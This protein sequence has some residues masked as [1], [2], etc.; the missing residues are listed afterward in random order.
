[1]AKYVNASENAGFKKNRRVQKKEYVNASERDEKNRGGLLE[2]AGYLAGN[3]GLG[4]AGVGEGIG[5]IVSAGA[6]LLRGDTEMAKYRFLDNRTA[7]AQQRLQE[8]YNPNWAMEIAGEVASGIGNSLVFMIPYAGRW[9]AGAG[10]WGQGI[11]KAADKTGDVGLKEVAF[12]L[13][14]AT[15]EFLLEKATGGM[16]FAAK[17]IGAS[18]IR[19][20]GKEAVEATGKA[21]G[22]KAVSTMGGSIGKEIA[23][24][25][26]GEAIEEMASEALDPVLQKAFKVDENAET[27]LENVLYAGLIGGLSGGLMTTGPA[28]MNYASAKKTG[29]TIREKGEAQEL[30]DYAKLLVNGA[31]RFASKSAPKAEAPEGAGKLQR[32]TTGVRNAATGINRWW[33][34]NGAKRLANTLQ[35]NISAYES[36]LKDPKV[37]ADKIKLYDAV[38]GE[39]RGN[40]FLLEADYLLDTYEDMILKESEENQQ[41]VVN[42]INERMAR[43]GA[44]KRDYTLE[45]LK[46]NEDGILTSYATAIMSEEISDVMKKRTGKRSPAK[47]PE[48]AK[49]ATKAAETVPVVQTPTQTQKPT[50][51]EYEPVERSLR[52]SAEG[53]GLSNVETDMM[54]S[55]FKR[56]TYMDADTFSKAFAEGVYYGRQNRRAEDVSK[57]TLFGTMSEAERSAAIEAGRIGAIAEEDKRAAAAA[58]MVKPARQPEQQ[59]KKTYVTLKLADGKRMRDMS[60]RD[61]ATYKAANVIGEALQTDIVLESSLGATESGKHING[62]F[63]RGDNTIHIALG[64]EQTTGKA[65]IFTLAH[66]TTHYIREWAPREYQKLADFVGERLSPAGQT[67]DDMIAT[68]KN[69]LK[70]L[71]DF[72]DLSESDLTDAA[73]EEVIADS[74]ETILT[75]GNVLED[76]ATYDKSLWE[77]VKEWITDAL[78]KIRTAFEGLKPNS[79]AAKVLTETMDS[80]TEL[81]RLFTEGVTAAGERT[82]GAVMVKDSKDNS[83][84]VYHLRDALRTLGEYDATRKR[85]IESSGK[86]RIVRNYDEI[87]AFIQSS[88]SQKEFERIHIGIINPKTANLVMQKTKQN[89]DGYDVVL[90]NEFIAHIFHDHGDQRKETPR[91]QIAV[92]T[93]NVEDLVEAMIDPDDVKAVEADTGPALRFEKSVGNKNVALTITSKKKGTLTLKSA[94]IVENSGGRTPSSNADALEETSE[95]NGRSSAESSIPQPDNSVNSKFSISEEN[96]SEQDENQDVSESAAD[97]NVGDTEEVELSDRDL[98]LAMAEQMVGTEEEYKIVADY[99]A[100][101]DGILAKQE[102]ADELSDR[103]WELQSLMFTGADAEERSNAAKELKVIR[104]ELNNLLDEVAKEDKKLAEIEGMKAIRNLITRE[105]LN[106]RDTFKTKYEGMYKKKVEAK[107]TADKRRQ[108]RRIYNK[109]NRLLFSPTKTRNVPIGLQG[110]VA[111]ALK[112]ANMDVDAMERLAQLEEQLSKLEREAVPDEANI[113]KLEGQIT[114]QEKK[115]GSIKEQTQFLI[116]LLEATNDPNADGETRLVFDA[117]TLQKLKDLQKD[118]GK[119]SVRGMDLKQLTA[120]KDFYD[121]I[122]HRI[123]KANNLLASER[124][125]SVNELGEKASGEVVDAKELKVLSPRGKEWKG[126]PLIRK[127]LW[128]NMKPLTFFEAIGS[129]TLQELFQNVI[130]GEDVWARDLMEAHEFLEKAKKEYGYNKWD[131]DKRSEVKTASGE[132]VSLTLGEKM[133]LYAYMFREQAEQHLSVGGFTFAPDATTIEHFK[134]GVI[135]YEAVLND[136]KQYRMRQEDIAEMAA[137]L[138]AEQKEYARKVQEYLTSLGK[139]GNEVSKKLYGIE[140]FNEQFYFPIRSNRDY[141][142]ESTGKSGDPNIKNQGTFQETVPGAGNPLVLEDFMTV[143]TGHI[144]NMATYHAF[145]LPVEDLTKVWNYTPVNMKRDENG[146]VILDDNGLPVADE[147]A[148][149]SYNSLKAE[150]TKKYGKE[151]NEYI[152]NLIRD[153]NGGARRDA[154]ASILDQG[155]TG[156]KRATTMLSMSTI[157]QQPT[158]I[159]RAMS[160]IDGKYFAGAEL[161]DWEEMKMLAPVAFLKEMGGHDTSTG[162]RTQ[163]YLN[164]KEYD[165]IGDKVK[166][167]L[168][169]K[170]YGGDPKAR[171]EAFGW[172]TSKADE[173]AWR[174]MFGACINE[175]AAKMGKPKDSKEVKEAAAKRF[176]EAVRKT[177]VYDSTLTRSPWMRSKDGLMKIVTSF[178]AEPTTV[179]SMIAE[180]IIKSE[181]GDKK[182]LR[183]IGGVVALSVLAN[184]IASSLIYAMRDDDEDETYAEKYLQSLT[185]EVIEGVN[186][187]EYMPIAREVM[188]LFKGYE[189][190]RTDMTLVSNL[191]EQVE[192]ITSSKRSLPDKLFGVSGAVAAF[193]GVPLTNVYRDAKGLFKTIMGFQTAESQTGA[194]FK[195]AVGDSVR[196]QFN[197]FSKLFGAESGN[198]YEM[199]QAYVRGDTAHYERVKARYES[200]T[201]AEQALRKELRENDKRIGEAAKARIEGEL[202]VYESL[203]EQ[204][205]AEGIFDRNIV[206]R[207]VNNEIILLK[208]DIERGN[209]VPEDPVEEETP[210]SIYTASDLNY[211]LERGEAED[212]TWIYHTLMAYKQEQQGKT[213][214]QARASIKTSVTSYWKKRYTAAW[215]ANNGAEMRRILKILLDTGLYGNH[216][217]TATTLEGWVKAYA[218]AKRK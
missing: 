23:K 1:M 159:F 18:V 121:M 218:K 45:D 107:A 176:T 97:T 46:N 20:T 141:L 195:H 169:P 90:S 77:K 148:A 99:K 204:I 149:R 130:D 24:G 127:F 40:T 88:P 106:V 17:N 80:L 146:E 186:P 172:L 128:G 82:K 157:I 137:S 181:R 191:F 170:T 22:R 142:A 179:M 63:K 74:L 92:T 100:K 76:L 66:E 81:E 33:T 198:A 209:L 94:W 25:F 98:L 134:N 119:A 39:L 182:A 3:L 60:D 47:A 213:E 10:Y 48:A 111:E 193:F 124:K 95:T 215:E 160:L 175:Q 192:M 85:H 55:A 194:G 73:Y 145:V 27:S 69:T 36:M 207:A 65:A 96:V 114:E 9:L 154:A 72:K 14:E 205:E 173:V 185:S 184:A 112:A 79:Q 84:I 168:K 177:Q 4:L 12:G 29:Q 187:L 126:L 35:K 2:G 64:S 150:I 214:A 147:D 135:K 104:D 89:I 113:R 101:Y 34:A 196:S 102:R 197:L 165:S 32:A 44:P 203:V 53:L 87:R 50:E 217:D 67:F 52:Q 38:L 118:I 144:N 183:T 116:E 171:A 188:S 5:D 133:S 162:A 131:M 212:F 152:L 28:V 83:G 16:G 78:A 167:A 61:Y 91:H 26:M 132:T 208:S 13:G 190:E 7:E 103:Q 163:D 211:A 158:S 206:I 19:N 151:A 37:T 6:D 202:E 166:A 51:S 21:I 123:T 42:E 139:K 189:I 110:L 155:I 140:L 86:D 117:E 138:T 210:E 54:V 41:A 156:F 49:E 68:K 56:G 153:L 105:R 174:L 125:I 161:A 122:H 199:Y 8:D 30:L 164:A 216:N 129:K 143:A 71:E 201:A 15:K 59:G 62:Y 93:A 11:S 200:D 70:T 136:Q 115:V 109:V 120:L 75:D 180:G 43:S 31:N 178:S 57:N 108:V 58:Q